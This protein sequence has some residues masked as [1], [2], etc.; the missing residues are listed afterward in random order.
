MKQLFYYA[1]ILFAIVACSKSEPAD[2]GSDNG[3]GNTSTTPTITL[4]KSSVSFD[5]FA[6]EE[7]ISFSA[8]ADWTAEIVN[9][10]ADSWLSVSPLSGTSGDASI[11]IKAKDNDTPDDRTAS[12]A[13]KAGS[14]TKTI[15]VS[16]KQKDA[17]TVTAS[18]FEVNAEGGEVKIEVKANIDFEYAIDESAKDW[19]KYEGTRAMKTSTLVFS[20]AE[21]DDT[22]KREGNIAIKSGEFNE[23][24]TIYQAGSEPSI[25]ISQNEYVVSSDGETIAVEVTSNVDVAVEMPADAD[26]ISENTTRATS[27]NTYRFDIQPNEDYDQRT[28]E[29]KFTNKENNLSEVVTVTQ[30][31]KDALVVA[32]DSYT[33]DSDG[34]QIQIEVGH[35][36]DFDV[37]ISADWITKA[38][39]TRAF[40]TETLTFNIAKNPNYDNREGTILFKSKDGALSQAVKVYQ[41]QEDALIISKKD[42]VVSCEGGIIEFEMQTNVE[43]EVSKTKVDWLHEVKTRGLTTHTLRY[44]V[45]ANSLYESRYATINIMAKDGTVLDEL[46]IKQYYNTPNTKDNIW[47]GSIADSYYTY[48]KGTEDSPYMIISCA[49]MAKLAEEVNQG[50]SFEGKHFIILAN[51]DFN[52]TP[53]IPIGNSE[54]TYFSG[55]FDGNGKKLS[56]LSIAPNRYKGLFGHIKNAT[57]NDIYIDDIHTGYDNK[58]YYVGGIAGYADKS[59]I[60]NCCT[61]GMV[62]GDVCAGSIVAYSTEGSSI[63]NCYSACQNQY[64]E[65]WGHIGGL[66]GYNCGDIQCCY[67]YGSINAMDYYPQTTGGIVGYNHSTA[68]MLTCYYL[69]SPAGA[70]QQL[71]FCGSLN[72]GTCYYCGSFN[73]WGQIN[74]SGGTNLYE[75]LNKWVNSRQTSDNYYRNWTNSSFPQFIY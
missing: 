6:D 31:Q 13:I 8:T 42:I 26:W 29:I 7:K 38:D 36:V 70:M 57:I 5:E 43:F 63:R 21:N 18:K 16:Q 67:Y 71:K 48:G 62:S 44:E 25:V 34:D 74:G 23:V 65:I 69:S 52:S 64:R 30:T 17:L 75:E 66:V 47:D 58:G 49:E 40:V 28:T 24:V 51:L 11:T 35:N 45:D 73:L 55:Y 50:N 41:A 60:T 2:N 72:W 3:G 54:D 32:K 9:D 68:Y 46:K 12:I 61:F 27:T 56:N 20:I 37:E 10:R 4:N 15:T 14:A 39:N 33:V 22:K 59:T 1:A 53:F 19:I